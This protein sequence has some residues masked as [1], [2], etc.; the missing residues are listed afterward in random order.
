[1]RKYLFSIKGFTIVEVLCSAIVISFIVGVLFYALSSGEYSR[2]ASAAKIDV[3]SEVRRSMDWIA[4]DVRQAVSWDIADT[5]NSPSDTH[6]KFRKVEGW[7]TTSELLLLS[8]NYTEYTYNTSNHTVIRR[9]SDSSNNTIQTWTLNN[10]QQAP[11]YTVNSSG[12]VVPLNDGDLLTSRKLILVINGTKPIKGSLNAT[13]TL[14]EEVK[15][16]NE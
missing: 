11:F 5:S 7:N 12:S 14:T 3:Q 16:R 13:A 15:I 10:I 9:L 6:I 1:M 8:N 4:R 2:T